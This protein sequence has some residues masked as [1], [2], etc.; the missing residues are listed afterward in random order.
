[1]PQHSPTHEVLLTAPGVDESLVSQEF[2]GAVMAQ[3]DQARAFLAGESGDIPCGFVQAT[4]AYSEANERDRDYFIEQFSQAF[5]VGTFGFDAI[6]N[7]SEAA[8]KAE[9]SRFFVQRP[10]SGQDTMTLAP[11]PIVKGRL[12]WAQGE[13]VPIE[14]GTLRRVLFAA[15]PGDPVKGKSLILEEVELPATKSQTG[16]QTMARVVL[17]KPGVSEPTGQ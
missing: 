1:M 9:E 16:E 10:E 7:A 2:H 11:G 5:G 3:I 12:G 17:F 14:G 6:M 8:M 4:D 15:Y 13:V